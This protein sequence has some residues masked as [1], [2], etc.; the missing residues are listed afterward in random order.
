MVPTCFW[1]RRG[2]KIHVVASL[3]LAPV[4]VERAVL[5]PAAALVYPGST[6]PVHR[7]YV[8]H[9]DDVSKKEEGGVT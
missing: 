2:S 5:L 8:G 3:V 9:E 6:D 4:Q 1:I 7:V